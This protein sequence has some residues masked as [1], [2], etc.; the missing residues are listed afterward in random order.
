MTTTLFRSTLLL[1]CAAASTLALC[2]ALAPTQAQT[3]PQPQAQPQAQTPPQPVALQK[4]NVRAVAH[5]DF[6]QATLRPEDRERMLAE[7]GLLKD[8]TWQ[9]VTAVGHT[10]S[11]GSP[12]YNQRLADERARAVRDYL[13]GKG[14]DPQMINTKALAATAPVADNDSPEG[15]A[16][17]RRT[18]IE[19]SGVRT[20]AR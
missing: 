2:A 17:N 11:V 15:R 20:A 5:F 6:D 14:L 19:F 12:G 4:V 18:E 10:D 8:V 9:T 3:Q 16:R 13:V 1:R 7:V